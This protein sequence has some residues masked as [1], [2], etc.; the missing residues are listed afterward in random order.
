MILLYLKAGHVITMVAWFAALFFLGRMYI[1]H[2]EALSAKPIKHA[3]VELCEGAE[4][5]I[6]YIILVPSAILTTLIGFILAYQINAFSQGWF[7]IKLSF[8]LIFFYYN[9]VMIK[10][11]KRFN[12]QS[13]T[14][15]VS[16]LRLL[17]EVPFIL[18][19]LIV[20]TVYL[21]NNL[22]FLIP[23]SVIGLFVLLFSVLS[24]VIKRFN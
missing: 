6:I 14:P 20:L 2:K 8:L 18:L 11:R 9:H 5:R 16:T 19:I 12:N 10:L 15:S 17:N 1:Y 4:K 7:H 3:V 21:K 23:I 22:N 13:K 24:R